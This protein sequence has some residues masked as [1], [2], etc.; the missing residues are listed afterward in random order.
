MDKSAQGSVQ[1]CLRD[2]F[3]SAG[4]FS[5]S[6]GSLDCLAH[7]FHLA[8]PN[9][10]KLFHWKLHFLCFPGIPILSNLNQYRR[11]YVLE[12]LSL[13]LVVMYTLNARLICFPCGSKCSTFGISRV[14]SIYLEYL[15]GFYIKR[16]KS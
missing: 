7:M 5:Y 1:L 11:S 10:M 3:G 14:A 13:L 15:E 16:R 9:P 4:L 6:F 12:K 2:A 8:G